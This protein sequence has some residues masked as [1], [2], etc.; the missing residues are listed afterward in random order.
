MSF[1]P[2]TIFGYAAKSPQEYEK[3]GVI[4]KTKDYSLFTGL[5]NNR[6]ISE[7]N[8]NKIL[9]N[10]RKFGILTNPIIVNENFEIVDGQHRFEAIKRLKGEVFFFV[11]EG[12]GDNEIQALNTVSKK[13][14]LSDYTAFYASKG[15][16]SFQDIEQLKAKYPQFPDTSLLRVYAGNST[17]KYYTEAR[18]GS[19]EVRDYKTSDKILSEL[20]AIG[21]IYPY[22]A[23]NN[24]VAAYVSIRLNKKEFSPKEF[25]KKIL[26]H[27]GKNPAFARTS[28]ARDFIEY[29][30]NYRRQN[31][32][33]LRF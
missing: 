6:P 31:K 33:N 5:P 25:L 17:G 20:W 22:F 28:Q 3:C 12:Y 2:E 10:M 18:D 32:I 24:F 30:Y 8:V 14:N 11:V 21:A 15:V 1:S 23:S 29:V 4:Y 26:A 7:R 13:W 16:K 9:A 19:L 27:T